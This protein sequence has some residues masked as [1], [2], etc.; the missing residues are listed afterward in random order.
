MRVAI[1][2]FLLT[3]TAFAQLQPQPSGTKENLRGI[4]IFDSKNIWASGAHGTYLVTKD[5]GVTWNVGKVPDADSFDLRG[6]RVFNKEVFVLAAGPGEK[7]RIY[8]LHVGKQW[9]L[10][11]TNQEPKGFFDCMAFSDPKHG[12]VVG[13]PAN[14]KFQ[15]LR[16]RDGG[17]H[18]QYADPQKMPPALVGESAFAASNSCIAVNGIQNVW[19]ATGGS[20]AR[21]FHSADAGETWSVSDT[22]ITHGAPSQ[23]IFSLAFRDSLHGVIAGGDYQHPEQGGTNLALTNDGGKTWKPVN[24]PGQRFFS[25]VAYIGSTNPE[26]V[27]VGSAAFGYSKNELRTWAWFSPDSF[28]AVDSKQGVVYAV[29]ADGKI[30]KLQK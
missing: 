18:W 26:I 7:S 17:R 22:P 21:V 29:G 15:I 3:S 25:A 23:G 20:A 10:Q 11:F 24:A 28:N 6:I 5:G 30:A 16:T 12:I 27:A 19:F 1:L 13:D 14:G 9:E 2:L 4:S 8:H